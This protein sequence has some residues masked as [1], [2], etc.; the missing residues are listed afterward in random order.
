MAGRQ[1]YLAEQIISTPSGTLSTAPQT[2]T[3]LSGDNYVQW[4]RWRFPPGPSGQLGIS[5][6]NLSAQIVPWVGEGTF[7]I[8]DN[9]SETAEV[10]YQAFKSLSLVSYNTGQ[11][12]HSII[13]SVQYQPIAVTIAQNNPPVNNQVVLIDSLAL[14]QPSF[15]SADEI[16]LDEVL[17]SQT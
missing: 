7:I 11:Y 1:W 6:W 12:A 16:P 2:T 13:I 3:V 5:F 8:G 9:E 15:I 17:V 10:D 4:I 14:S